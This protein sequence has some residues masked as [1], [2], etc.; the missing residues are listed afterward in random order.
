MLIVAPMQRKREISIADMSFARPDCRDRNLPLL[1]PHWLI[2]V[3]DYLNTAK[4]DIIATQRTFVSRSSRLLVPVTGY[5]NTAKEGIMA[6]QRAFARPA[7]LV[8]MIPSKHT[9]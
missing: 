7:L 4:E 2:P 8:A 5:L 1:F 9:Y 6:T 3:I